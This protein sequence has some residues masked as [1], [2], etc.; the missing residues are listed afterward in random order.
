[1]VERILWSEAKGAEVLEDGDLEFESSN[2]GDVLDVLIRFLELPR[3]LRSS[4]FRLTRF[5]IGKEYIGGL[6]G[7]NEPCPVVDAA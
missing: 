1:M 4:A 6:L 2:L 5:L 3:T 7:S